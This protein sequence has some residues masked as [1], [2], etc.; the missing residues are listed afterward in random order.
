MAATFIGLGEVDAFTLAANVPMNSGDAIDNSGAMIGFRIEEDGLG[1]VDTVYSDRAT[2]FTNIGDTEGG[3]LVAHTFKKLGFIYD[4]QLTGTDSGR[5]ENCCVRFFQDNQLCATG[6]TKST[7]TGL[8]NLDANALGLLWATAADS[9]GTSFLGS[10]K[11]WRVA[12]LF[13][14]VG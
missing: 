2:S 5:P 11:W 12:Q 13:T 1:V 8:T 10:L 3:T 4:P 7:L 9:G 6:L 14:P